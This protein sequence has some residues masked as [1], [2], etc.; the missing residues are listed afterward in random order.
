MK[1]KVQLGI[2]LRRQIPTL[3][4]FAIAL[5][6]LLLVPLQIPLSKT[7]QNSQLGPRFVPTVMLS[8]AAIFSVL[9]MASEA[10]A[11]FK[12]GESCVPF[13]L[14]TLRQ[15][16]KV[17]LLVASLLIWYVLLKP[18]GFVI[19][20]AMLMMISMYLLGNRRVWQII[21]IPV[22]VSTGIYLLFSGLLNVPLPSGIL[23]M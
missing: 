3:V 5:G 7:A 4:T 20:T 19:M 10:Y 6:A 14:A 21:A 8:G 17:A 12:C 16:G 23:P 11:C 9:S 1:K 13:Q 22:I 18:V 2:F 15:Y